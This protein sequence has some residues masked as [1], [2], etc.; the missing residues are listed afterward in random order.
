MN[1][2]KDTDG[3]LILCSKKGLK[4]YFSDKEFSYDFPEGILPLINSGIVLAIVTESG[5]DITGELRIMEVMND[6]KDYALA[7]Q[8]KFYLEEDDEIFI[9]GH[10]E[11]TQAC[12]NNKGDLD[13][14][15][16][17]NDKITKNDLRPGW[18]TVFTH[19]K[20]SDEPP[21]LDII[22]QLMYEDLEP[23]YEEVSE[24]YAV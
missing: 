13:A 4:K 7:S 18:T 16:F 19:F 21:Y 24:I 2:E 11:F 17:W 5:E 12:S 6:K 14:F 8:N 3:V 23:S 20:T 10:S 1:F 9:L 15:E 22:F